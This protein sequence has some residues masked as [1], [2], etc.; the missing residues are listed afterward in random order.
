VNPFLATN[1]KYWRALHSSTLHRNEHAG[2]DTLHFSW[3]HGHAKAFDDAAP[4]TLSKRTFRARHRPVALPPRQQLQ[5]TKPRAFFFETDRKGDRDRPR[6]FDFDPV[7]LHLYV[8]DGKQKK[9]HSGDIESRLAETLPPPSDNY[10]ERFLDVTPKESASRRRRFAGDKKQRQRPH[11]SHSP[12]SNANTLPVIDA[13]SP[14]SST[15]T[16]SYM[17][18][19]SSSSETNKEKDWQRY[20]Q[21]SAVDD[22]EAKEARAAKSTLTVEQLY[23]QRQ[24]KRQSTGK[25]LFS[26]GDTKLRLTKDADGGEI[27]AFMQPHHAQ[28]EREKV[29]RANREHIDNGISAEEKKKSEKQRTYTERYRDHLEKTGKKD[30]MT[31]LTV[32]NPWKEEQK[33]QANSPTSP[34][35]PNYMALT[36]A[37]FAKQSEQRQQKAAI[38]QRHAN[39]RASL[40]RGVGI[41]YEQLLAAHEEKEAEKRAAA[42]ASPAPFTG[43]NSFMRPTT[44]Q[45]EAL[46]WQAQRKLALDTED[47]RVKRID[48]DIRSAAQR[49]VQS[50]QQ[51]KVLC[52]DGTNVNVRAGALYMQEN[53]AQKER[54]AAMRAQL[55]A[56]DSTR[57]EEAAIQNGLAASEAVQ[58]EQARLEG[59]RSRLSSPGKQ[60]T[61]ID[62]RFLKTTTKAEARRAENMDQLNELRA[63][64]R[65]HKNA[66]PKQ[67]AGI[68]ASPAEMFER[69]TLYYESKAGLERQKNGRL[70]KLSRRS[71]RASM[72]LQ[73]AMDKEREEY[74]A[75]IGGKAASL[76]LFANLA[77]PA[78][79]QWP[80]QS[81]RDAP[82]PVYASSSSAAGVDSGAFGASNAFDAF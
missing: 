33:R 72:K 12:S 19:T 28:T 71:K 57:N 8:D 24:S 40:P 29:T 55:Q 48:A 80:P 31:P 7:L 76:P 20:A 69:E 74:Y 10:D 70:K 36:P 82:P 50:I 78:S 44:A 75:K 14:T 6:L 4:E 49:G 17:K 25:A 47:E 46:A 51:P 35:S 3:R 11:T 68:T 62:E 22:N 34:S 43:D 32:D 27:L 9:H 54:A 56:M 77:M 21:R 42:A 81:A 1:T 41:S 2:D 5:T 65:A 16:P 13:P 23:Q 39:D 79:P 53:T 73:E 15:S 18:K 37:A 63:K 30:Y 45:S 52:L 67:T 58:R 64:E 38:D 66:Q 26:G 59:V 60:Q 61:L